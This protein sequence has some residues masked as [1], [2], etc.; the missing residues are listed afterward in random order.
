M[1]I[2]GVYTVQSNENDN[3]HACQGWDTLLSYFIGSG[4][5]M[6]TSKPKF[7]NGRSEMVCEMT[8]CVL[9]NHTEILTRMM[10]TR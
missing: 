2:A 8:L 10:V 6:V 1:C 9:H 3:K 7:V 4:Q 5:M